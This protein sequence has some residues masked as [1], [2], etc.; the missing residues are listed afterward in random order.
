MSLK[1]NISQQLRKVRD[2]IAT[3]QDDGEFTQL[4]PMS[5]SLD[6]ENSSAKHS[7]PDCLI[8][9]DDQS[10]VVDHEELKWILSHLSHWNLEDHMAEV[11]YYIFSAEYLAVRKH[12]G[13]Q[14]WTVDQVKQWTERLRFV[15]GK[16]LELGQSVEDE[17]V[18]GECFTVLCQEKRLT[19]VLGIDYV[20]CMLL[21]LIVTSWK[22][23]GADF[24]LPASFPYDKIG[25]KFS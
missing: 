2:L 15:R 7:V 13:I 1:R 16:G 8:N 25:K 24:V 11:V 4:I 10:D 3:K 9:T 17:C 6:E 18:D 14:N 20:C 22:E 23:V 5:S 21:E 12:G 19:E